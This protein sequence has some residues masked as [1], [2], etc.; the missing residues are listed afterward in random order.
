MRGRFFSFTLFTLPLRWTFT[1]IQ[2]RRK[3]LLYGLPCQLMRRFL[4]QNLTPENRVY[5]PRALHL[6]YIN[7]TRA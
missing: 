7:F 5:A 3:V 1:G 2:E 6:L 4:S